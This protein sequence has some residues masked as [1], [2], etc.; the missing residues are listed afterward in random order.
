MGRFPY[1]GFHSR[2]ET[3][4]QRCRSGCKDFDSEIGNENRMGKKVEDETATHFTVLKKRT[5]V[6]FVSLRSL[7]FNKIAHV[8]AAGNDN[9]IESILLK[10]AEIFVGQ[11]VITWLKILYLKVG[12][13]QL[14]LAKLE[15]RDFGSPGEAIEHLE[16]GPASIIDPRKKIRLD[17][18]P[19]I[20]PGKTR[21]NQQS[22][23]HFQKQSARELLC[24]SPDFGNGDSCPQPEKRVQR[25]QSMSASCFKRAKPEENS[26]RK[27][28]E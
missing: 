12:R 27:D 22:K 26:K 8:L 1:V 28:R 14:K 3:R 25:E 6:I 18:A 21:S 7:T 4:G 17:A 16:F 10:P 24:D 11:N 2:N 20:R 13:V 5:E 19:V 15:Q 23:E 9:V